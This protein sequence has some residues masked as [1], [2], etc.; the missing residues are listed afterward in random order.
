MSDP[1]APRSRVVVAGGGAAGLETL[2]ALQAMAAERVELP[3][4]APEDEFVYRPL[5]VEEPYAVGRVR[6]VPLRDAAR[7][8][9]ATFIGETIAEIDPG[10]RTAMTDEKTRV[11]YDALVLATGAEP[12]PA[13][14]GALTWDDRVK[15]E[16]L[17]GLLRDIEDG[18]TRRVAVIVPPG[19]GW[20][21]RGYELAVLIAKDATGMGMDAEVTL[22]TPEPSP[23]AP[24]E[25]SAVAQLLEA[26]EAAGVMLV[27]DRS[28]SVD[29]GPPKSVL[30]QPSGRR[31]Q[32]DRVLALPV[33]HGRPLVGVA[34]DER[35]FFEVDEHCRVRAVDGVWAV[36]DATAFEL[37][38]GGYATEQADVAA[39]DIA[40]T[41]GVDVEPPPFD[42]T[43]RA[44]V[45]GL[46]AGR[47][48]SA[49]LAADDDGLTTYLPT[50]GVSVMTY[51][52]RDF[53]G[54][55]RGER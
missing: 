31:F 25:R 4:V 35:G 45:G 26:V 29:A 14:D 21:L 30:L 52:R 28:A 8:A 9:A 15:A 33:L 39:A 41:A 3:L 20:P 50:V 47:H 10:T 18:Y 44:D 48:L 36:G 51:L 55:F 24:L 12:R 22:V 27:S 38:S 40:A 7:D 16:A 53:A 54:S 6:H 37:K 11:D 5:A 43:P 13:V 19:P 42:A 46:P 49:W 32:V 2:M 17:G 34:A 1:S 23:L